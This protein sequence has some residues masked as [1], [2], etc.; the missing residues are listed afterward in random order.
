ME[1]LTE[2]HLHGRIHPG[3]GMDNIHHCPVPSYAGKEDQQ[4]NQTK[5]AQNLDTDGNIIEFHSFAFLLKRR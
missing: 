1:L 3:T 2:F 4:G 5:A